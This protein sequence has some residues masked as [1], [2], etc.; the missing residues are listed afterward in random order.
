MHNKIQEIMQRI[1]AGY[2]QTKFWNSDDLPYLIMDLIGV[3]D[4]D[5]EN[6]RIKS[7]LN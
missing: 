4:V 7:I 2:S 1:K 3:K 6:V 5:G